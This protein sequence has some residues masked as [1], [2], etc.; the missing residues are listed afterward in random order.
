MTKY[1]AETRGFQHFKPPSYFYITKMMAS[2]L[3]FEE[4]CNYVIQ[5]KFNQNQNGI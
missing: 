5:V 4:S 1:M 2:Y 3:Y